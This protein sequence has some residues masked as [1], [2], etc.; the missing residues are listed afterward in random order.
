MNLDD[1]S[2]LTAFQIRPRAA[3]PAIFSYAS[4]RDPGGQLVVFDRDE[5]SFEPIRRVALAAHRCDL[6]GRAA[7]SRR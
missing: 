7:H 4:L 5:V 2:A 1:G 3:G 6:S